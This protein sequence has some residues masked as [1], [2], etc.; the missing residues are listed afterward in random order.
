MA[1]T[2]TGPLEALYQRVASL[3]GALYRSGLLRRQALDR[4]TVSVGG[5]R[6]GGAGKTPLVRLLARPTDAILTRGYGGR[7]RGA[8]HVARGEGTDGAPWAR[9]VSV[10]GHVRPARDWSAQL[11]DEPALLAAALPGIPVGVCP[12]RAAAARAIV[13]DADPHRF[14]LDDGFS[15][16]R[17]GRDADLVVI[18]VNARGEGLG[19]VR[20]RQREGDAALARAD[21]LVL[22]HDGVAGLDSVAADRAGSELAFRGPLGIVRR[23]VSGVW[24]WPDGEAAGPADLARCTL[25]PICAIGRPDS[26]RRLVEGFPGARVLEGRAYR[27][28]HRFGAHEL[29]RDEATARDLGA[30]AVVSTVKDAMRLPADWTPSLPWWI[31]EAALVW[32]RGRESIEEVVTP[33]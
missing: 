28:H 19:P 7:V 31:V 18:P 21:G 1:Y 33:P 22:L 23:S 6:F 3:H 10:G 13:G 26:F 12:D 2:T 24:R 27:D 17:L 20:G 29:A 5:L 25:F 16:H 9:P 32:D 30:D 11:G 8:P 4:F 15:H 14:V